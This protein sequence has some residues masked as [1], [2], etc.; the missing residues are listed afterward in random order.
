VLAAL[1]PAFPTQPVY[2]MAFAPDPAALYV[3]AGHP[4]E[5]F[6][7][8]NRIEW[9]SGHLAHLRLARPEGPQSLMVTRDGRLATSGAA[10][11]AIRD[12]RTLRVLARLPVDSARAALAPDGRTLLAGASDG[13]VHF[14]DL[15]TGRLRTAAGGHQGAVVGAAFGPDGRTAVTAG[16]DNRLIVWDVARATATETLTGH[17]GRITGMAIDRAGKTLYTTSLDGR[18]LIWDLS[19]ARRLGRPFGIGP[20]NQ[21]DVAHEHPSWPLLVDPLLS[22]ALRPDGR[23]LAAGQGDGTVTLTDTRTLRPLARLRV[24]PGGPVRGL[25]YVPHSPLLVAGGDHG[26]LALV[27][28]GSGRI[29]RLAGHAG[30]LM[31]PS[32]SADGRLMATVSAGDK[33]ML[34]TLRG[35]RPAGRPRVY[36]GIGDNTAGPAGASL[37]PDGRRLAISSALG[38]EIADTATLRR[39]RWLPGTETAKYLARFTPDG[40]Y[41][42]AASTEG[43]VRLWSTRTWRPAT[44]ALPTGTSDVLW[45]SV[46]PDGHTLAT[47]GTDGAIRLFDLRTQ[48]PLGRPLPGLPNHPI[49][50][51]FTPGG[52][53]LLAVT[54]AGQAFRWDVRPASWASHACAVAGRALTRAEWADA[55]PGRPYAPA[56][57]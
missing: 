49:G 23:V 9:R 39:I 30:T 18:L 6:N 24:V 43:W 33:V 41:L 42:V 28:P 7:G 5:G 3:A 13:T 31:A 32:F 56:C 50:P 12:P 11:T 22:Y 10:G 14:A 37:S 57:R 29:D 38:V 44:R 54:D 52:G 45:E 20:G 4:A 1:R 15:V 55:L 48:Q 21:V 17:T 47:G 27:D 40:R 2:A 25:G 53:Y 8:L 51:A 19:G 46:S 34:W 35:G 36:G 26:F 16:E